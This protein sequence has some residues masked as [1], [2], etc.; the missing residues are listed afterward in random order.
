MFKRYTRIL[1]EPARY[2]VA[3][4]GMLFAS[5]I[6]TRREAEKANRFINKELK[7]K[8]SFTDADVARFQKMVD[9]GAFK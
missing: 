7:K 1:K 4:N 5:N 6:E 3:G 8:D 2:S 9:K